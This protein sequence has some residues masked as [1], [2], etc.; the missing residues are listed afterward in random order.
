[1]DGC[2]TRLFPEAHAA[3]LAAVPQDGAEELRLHIGQ[4]V[5]LRLQGAEKV[6]WPELGRKDLEDVIQRACRQSVYA[7]S[8]TIRQGYLNL[9]HGHRLGICGT[10]VVRNGQTE[11][12]RTP[13]SISIR[14]AREIPGC[15]GSLAAQCSGST[16]ILGPPGCGK[17]TLLRDLIRQLSDKKKQRIGLADERGEVSGAVEGVP[18]MQ[19]GKRTDV[20]LNV[21][22]AEAVMMLVR[23]MSPQWIAVDEITRQQ[24]LEAMV[25]ACYCGVNLLATAHGSSL[26][27]L[28]SRPLYR[29]LV[30]TGVFQTVVLMDRNKNFA[31]KEAPR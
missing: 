18:S 11:T 8:E 14:I 27:D 17:T 13:S 21:P 19:V 1:M 4:P 23:T 24:D 10:G 15:S 29:K 3:Q 12:I 5:L 6:L 31:L 26:D 7:H 28:C 22:K 25:Q 9:E 20:L 2:I 30:D 16:L